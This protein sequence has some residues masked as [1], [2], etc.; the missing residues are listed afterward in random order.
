MPFFS[1]F[2]I[3]I[4]K[5]LGLTGLST[6]SPAV[7]AIAQRDSCRIGC[8]P[9]ALHTNQFLAESVAFWISIV[10]LDNLLDAFCDRFCRK[11]A[12]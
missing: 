9:G 6:T 8:H 11:I 7:A 12:I 2:M 5:T 10:F 3:V 4:L 1:W